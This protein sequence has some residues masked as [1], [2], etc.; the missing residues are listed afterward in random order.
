MGGA[1]VNGD[2]S[3]GAA[4]A[5]NPRFNKPCD[6]ESNGQAC[7]NNKCAFIHF[8]ANSRSY[9]T[10]N[11]A[12]IAQAQGQNFTYVNGQ[13]IV[14]AQQAPM[15]TGTAAQWVQSQAGQQAMAPPPVP[16]NNNSNNNNNDYNIMCHQCG[17]MGHR[18]SNCPRGP[19]GGQQPQ[20]AGA[21][22][23]FRCGQVGHTQNNCPG[24]Q[25]PQTVYVQAPNQQQNKGKGKRGSGN[26]NGGQGQ[27]QPVAPVFVLP[28]QQGGGRR[29]SRQSYL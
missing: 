22:T 13:P 21:K 8:N 20:V 12:A 23:C 7:T 2:N 17:L 11:Q 29:W 10:T 16:K 3:S 4:T 18:K 25:G 19:N 1:A 15:T 5:R 28:G 14:F 26:G 9:A 24:G 27:Q 6:K